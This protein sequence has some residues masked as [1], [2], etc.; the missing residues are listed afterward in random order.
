MSRQE[1][2][3]RSDKGQSILEFAFVIPFVFFFIFLVIQLCLSFIAAEYASYV[4]FMTA[5]S[6]LTNGHILG[7]DVSVV[8]KYISPAMRRLLNI[9]TPRLIRFDENNRQFVNADRKIPE[10]SQYGKRSL[11]IELNYSIPVFLPFLR[12]FGNNLRFTSRTILGREPYHGSS[13][14]QP[15]AAR[16]PIFGDSLAPD[17]ACATVYN[18]NGC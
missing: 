16:S 2:L 7:K 5:R 3:L 13:P 8:N 9:D 12:E 1:H 17:S 4:S 10:G 11:G 18:D 6:V 14:V 15:F